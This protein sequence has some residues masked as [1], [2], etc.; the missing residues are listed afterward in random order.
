VD[1]VL[2]SNHKQVQRF[3]LR[4]RVLAQDAVTVSFSPSAQL[5]FDFC[6]VQVGYSIN[7]LAVY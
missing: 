7:L 1:Q 2:F 4:I 6:I 5:V 3:E